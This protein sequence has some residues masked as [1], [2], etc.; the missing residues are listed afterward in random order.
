MNLD[1]KL[2]AKIAHISN[3]IKG[4]NKYR[5]HLMKLIRSLE[6]DI[7]IDFLKSKK[8]QAEI[9]SKKTKIFFSHLYF[10]PDK[11]CIEIECIVDLNNKTYSLS[12]KG[13]NGSNFGFIHGS[14]DTYKLWK[15]ILIAIS[16]AND[17]CLELVTPK[18]KL[19]IKKKVSHE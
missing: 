6:K 13:K 15:Y 12:P 16:E 10:T 3:R 1:E 9:N 7:S 18:K 14:K 5:L 8:E 2:Y 11:E 19:I 17:K 4:A